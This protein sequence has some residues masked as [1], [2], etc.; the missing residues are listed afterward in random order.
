MVHII[1][2]VGTLIAILGVVV[3]IVPN[4]LRKWLSFFSK[5]KLVYIPIV[6]RIIL[7]VI[8]LI[9]AMQATVPWVI[10][11]FGILMTGAGVIFLVMPYRNTDKLLKWW[12][13]QPVWVYRVWA[14]LAAVLG[15]IIMYAG[16]PAK[17]M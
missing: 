2:I 13:K 7:G 3:L 14:V 8:F 6:I 4:V 16:V 10:I 11:L 5:G 9:Y 1:W 15:G 12:Q 17:G